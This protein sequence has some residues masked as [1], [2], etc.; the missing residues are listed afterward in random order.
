MISMYSRYRTLLPYDS[1]RQHRKEV[2][3]DG[4]RSI[5]DRRIVSTPSV[6]ASYWPLRLISGS[7]ESPGLPQQT[8]ITSLRRTGKSGI[9]KHHLLRQYFAAPLANI[10]LEM[11]DNDTLLVS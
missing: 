11:V 5:L 9:R 4:A 3:D 8:P 6:F 7:I 1:M 2:I 10:A